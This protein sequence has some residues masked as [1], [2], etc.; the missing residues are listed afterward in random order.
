M[1]RKKNEMR[2]MILL[3]T[4][5]ADAPPSAA[6]AGAMTARIGAAAESGMLVDTGG[7]SDVDITRVSVTNGRLEET[8]R[9]RDACD[10]VVGGYAILDVA[11]RGEAVATARGMLATHQQHWPSW[12]GVAEVRPITSPQDM[13]PD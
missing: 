6:L 12:D 3:T 1:R 13:L 8:C 10:H 9:P 7:L 4:R 2:F 5:H 11:T